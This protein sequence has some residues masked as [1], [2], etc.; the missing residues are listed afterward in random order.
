MYPVK[1]QVDFRKYVIETKKK[2]KMLQKIQVVKGIA[3]KAFCGYGNL[4]YH[5]MT[6]K[7]IQ[8]SKQIFVLQIQQGEEVFIP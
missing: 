5:K 8:I 4:T 1:K 6:L 3:Y 2:Q 7:E